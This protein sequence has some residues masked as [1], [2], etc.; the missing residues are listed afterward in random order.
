MTSRRQYWKRISDRES[1][2][3]KRGWVKRHAAMM[4]R[5]V[6]ADTAR[7]RALKDRKG[8]QRALVTVGGTGYIVRHSMRRHDSFDVYGSD[9]KLVCS[10]GRIVVGR[11]LGGLL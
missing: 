3:A 6:D 5:E 9:G 7:W 2:R 4:G 8:T 10:G 11:F 1:K